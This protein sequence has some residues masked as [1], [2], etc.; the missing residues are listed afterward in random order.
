MWHLVCISAPGDDVALLLDIGNYDCVVKLDKKL[1]MKMLYNHIF[2]GF[3]I[4]KA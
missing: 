4:L 1:A 2:D 3:L